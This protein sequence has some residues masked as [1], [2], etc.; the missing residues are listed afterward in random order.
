[1]SAVPLEAS[2]GASDLL[3]QE[4]Q[5]VLIH[6]AGV[7]GIEL[8]STGRALCALNS[9]AICSAPPPFL[10]IV[11]RHFLRGFYFLFLM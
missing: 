6:T 1:M 2:R 10:R 11:S 5:V 3:E 9:L 4:L 7:L 8:M